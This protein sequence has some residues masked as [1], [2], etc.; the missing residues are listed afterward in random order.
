MKSVIYS[1]VVSFVLLAGMSAPANAAPVQEWTTAIIKYDMDT[2]REAS[3][4]PRGADNNNKRRKGR[5][6]R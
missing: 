5:R 1:T 3:E 4:G 6:A 2:A